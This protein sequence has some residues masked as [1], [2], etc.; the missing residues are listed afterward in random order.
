MSIRPRTAFVLLVLALLGAFAALNWAAV[1]APTS[2]NLLLGRVEAPI[3]LAMLGVAV[4]LTVLYLLFAATTETAALLEARRHAREMDAQRRLAEEA[5]A[6]RLAGLRRY[7]EGELERLEAR[8]AEVTP[9]I[10]ERLDRLEEALRAEIERASNTLAAYIGE[11]EERLV[12][13]GQAPSAG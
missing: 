3:G 7:L 4:G 9:P 2:L 6:S 13:G 5:E 10:L 1:T 12:R 11:L 8:S